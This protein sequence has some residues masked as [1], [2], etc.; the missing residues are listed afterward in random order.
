MIEPRLALEAIGRV[1]DIEIDLAGAALQLAR[2]DAPDEDWRV[3][4]AHL[5]EIAREAVA[6]ASEVA[7]GDIRMRAAALAHVLADRHGYRGDRETYDDPANANLIHVIA[8]RRGLPVSLGILWMH[9]ATAAGWPVHGVDF[10]SHF[11]VALE[12]RGGPLPI[13]VFAGG[14][15]LDAR[16]LRTLI[17]SIEGPRAEIRPGLLQPMPARSVLLRLQNNIVRRRYD[18]GDLP[19]ALTAIED[20]LRFAG[21]QASLWREAA[22]IHQRLDRVGAAISCFERFLALVPHGDAAL[23]VRA[24]MDALRT[25]LN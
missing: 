3:A 4:R 15:P 10:P 23:K 5:S 8:R 12:G 1:P 19:G 7:A 16:G 2:I 18:A 9:C 25:R 6:V 17:K 22:I 13:D 21:D 24:Q 20:M 14:T 11:L